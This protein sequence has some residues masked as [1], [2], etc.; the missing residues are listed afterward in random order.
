[1]AIKHFVE[2]PGGEYCGMKNGIKSLTRGWAIRYHCLECSGHNHAEV[3]ECIIKIC[4]LWPFRMGYGGG[5][6]RSLENLTP[7]EWAR[8]RRY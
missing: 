1:M 8:H 3:R 2:F 4:P 5:D 6:D 7:D